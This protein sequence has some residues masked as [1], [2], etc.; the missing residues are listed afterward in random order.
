M[1]NFNQTL[2][3]S[4]RISYWDDRTQISPQ[5]LDTG[6]TE[7][8]S[9]DTNRSLSPTLASPGLETVRDEDTNKEYVRHMETEK[10]TVDYL[11]QQQPG[12]SSERR[13]LCG[14]R[15]PWL[16]VVL[17][18]ALFIAIALGVGLGVGLRRNS[19]G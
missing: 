2:K 11:P 15:S 3:R 1:Q 6:N 12:S 7:E 10:E 18:A 5:R 8:V 17:G 19:S 4:P 13:T 9:V 14:L 16:C